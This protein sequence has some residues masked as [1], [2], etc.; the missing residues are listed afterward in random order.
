M[1]KNAGRS[2]I[3]ISAF[4]KVEK[5]IGDDPFYHATQAVGLVMA[6]LG[7]ILPR[8]ISLKFDGK[9]LEYIGSFQII[10]TF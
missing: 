3:L 5:G 6:V 8:S 1:M 9:A 7:A 10:T 2:V 4:N